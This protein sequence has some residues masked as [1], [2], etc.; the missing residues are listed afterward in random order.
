MK[1][2]MKLFPLLLSLLL[3]LAMPPALA[4]ETTAEPT[5]APEYTGYVYI[6][7][8]GQFRWYPLALTPEES[9][10]IT[11]RSVAEDGSELSNV[12]AI[13]DTGVYMES[14]TCENQNCVQ[15]GTVTLENRETR[16]LSNYI[17]CL[18]QQ[19]VVQLY[20]AE[21][22]NQWYQAYIQSQAE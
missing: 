5:A 7:A 1:L 8:N 15:E 21:E 16:I 18:P 11:V 22:F 4:E 14:S 6:E 12:I 3:G 19:V 20:S 17:L 9:Y 2:R 13:T 10:H